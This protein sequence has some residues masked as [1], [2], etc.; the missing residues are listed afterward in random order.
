MQS[1]EYT[2]GKVVHDN[3]ESSYIPL[4]PTELK[5]IQTIR[6]AK[7]IMEKGQK[8]LSIKLAGHDFVTAFPNP[9]KEKPNQPDFKGDGIAVWVKVFE[10][11]EKPK[12]SDVL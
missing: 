9:K 1:T 6:E 8:Y 5:L 3:W 12:S 11:K 10:G 7:K 2:S 4:N